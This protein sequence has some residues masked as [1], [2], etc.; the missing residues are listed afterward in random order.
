[1]ALIDRYETGPFYDEMFAAPRELRPHYRRL[2]DYL[3]TLTP[4]ALAERRRIADAAFL[5]QGITFTVY[6][7]EDGLERIFPFDVV[8][9]IIPQADRRL[10]HVVL[11]TERAQAC[12]AQQQVFAG[13]GVES[14][15]A[16]AEH[17]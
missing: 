13:R 15:P 16:G 14:E 8:P 2:Y 11:V 1:M 3:N 12:S 10:R 17:A 6:G 5:N 9:R 7:Q 4:E